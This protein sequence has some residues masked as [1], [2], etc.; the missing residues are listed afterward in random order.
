MMNTTPIRIPLY[1][2]LAAG[3]SGCFAMGTKPKQT[4][5]EVL[6]ENEEWV[7]PI[8]NAQSRYGTPASLTLA[9]LEMPLSDIEKRHIYP[10]TADWDEYRVRT[11]NWAAST[12]SPRYSVDFIGWFTHETLKRNN[13]RWSDVSAHYLSYRLGHGGYH[14]FEPD[15]YP[16]LQQQ[17]ERVTLQA[18]RWHQE[19]KTCQ[20]QV[21]G[22]SWYSKLKFW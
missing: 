5:C 16:E 15:K 21:E 12:R 6:Q 7:E 17:A 4:I 9:L 8:V 3:L 14:R 1:L 10:R 13:V 2:A 11:E 22:R 20:L 19:L 18:Q